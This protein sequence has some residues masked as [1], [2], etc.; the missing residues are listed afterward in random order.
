MIEISIPR[1]LEPSRYK[2]RASVKYLEALSV[3]N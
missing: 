2:V 1:V 3:V